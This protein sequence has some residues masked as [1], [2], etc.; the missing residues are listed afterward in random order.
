MDH[1]QNG[2]QLHNSKQVM[3]LQ[4][5]ISKDCQK[6]NW[7]SQTRDEWN[8]NKLISIQKSLSSNMQIYLLPEFKTP[9]D[10][11]PW[12]TIVVYL[13]AIWRIGGLDFL[14]VQI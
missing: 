2:N 12:C 6:T 14:Q 9:S 11:S 10:V 3:N 4:A 13:N 1:S 7:T 8:I 5:N